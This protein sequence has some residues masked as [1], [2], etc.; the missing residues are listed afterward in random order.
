MSHDPLDEAEL[1]PQADVGDQD[2][3]IT[4]WMAIQKLPADQREAFYL[5]RFLGFTS[6]EAA[7]MIGSR[8]STVR[9]RVGNADAKLDRELR[10]N[11]GAG[12]RAKPNILYESP[13]RPP[14][15]RR[16][17]ILPN[18]ELARRRLAP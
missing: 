12:P 17:A 13:P 18:D 2:L 7:K 5:V 11:G 14:G 16:T 1:A 4:L 15:F 9:S 10:E 3:W 8:A 6:G